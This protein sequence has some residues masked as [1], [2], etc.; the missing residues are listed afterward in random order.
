M[1]R[2]LAYHGIQGERHGLDANDANENLKKRK[3]NKK[4]TTY[5]KLRNRVFF[6][7]QISCKAVPSNRVSELWKVPRA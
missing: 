3:K 4:F 5:S 6:Q 7:L 1:E 2:Y